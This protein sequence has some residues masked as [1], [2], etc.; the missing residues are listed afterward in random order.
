MYMLPCYS[1]QLDVH[2]TKVV[3]LPPLVQITGQA[4]THIEH[5]HLWKRSVAFI[6]NNRKKF[7][8]S[9]DSRISRRL[10]LMVKKK[11]EFVLVLVI[12][13]ELLPLLWT[14]LGWF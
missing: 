10:P 2:E 14:V 5:I 12:S 11:D 13:Q 3:H 9:K 6:I 4:P 7:F 8:I 1:V